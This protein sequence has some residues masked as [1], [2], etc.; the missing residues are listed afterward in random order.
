MSW[1][2]KSLHPH[3]RAVGFAAAPGDPARPSATPIY[4]TATFAQESATEFGAFDYSRSGNPT[5]AVLERHLAAIEYP[6]GTA[7]GE[8]ARAFAFA[9]GL[10]A[11]SAAVSILR[12]GDELVACDDLYGGSYRLFLRVLEPRGVVVRYA[13]LADAGVASRAFSEKTRLVHF[14]TPTN[15][16]QRIVDIRGIVRAVRARSPR[17]MVLVDS[18]A[19]SPWLQRPLELGADMVMHSATKLL[20]GHADVTAGALVMR[21]AALAE[22]IAFI[23]NAEGAALGPFDSYLLLRGMKTLGVRIERQQRG[24]RRVAAW[25]RSR[26]GVGEVYFP[27]TGDCESA[28]VHAS[29]AGG[30]GVVIS[31]RTGDAGASRALVES[32]ELF[33]IAVS[34]GSVNSTAS[35]PCRMSHASIPDAVRAAR[36][37]PEDLVRL[38]IGL[39]EAEDLI[40]DLDRA[41][42]AALGARRG[43]GSRALDPDEDGRVVGAGVGADGSLD[44]AEAGGVEDVIEPDAGR[45][46]EAAGARPG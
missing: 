11:L 19:M 37:M 20:N 18:T 29:Q 25:L 16:L 36:R 1:Q 27:G 38:S 32:L 35:L 30:P 22:Q 15:P 12:P 44:T 10:A 14:E 46:R 7:R 39:E 26:P 6:G 4:Q 40:G 9:S 33:S 42:E 24:A 43:S 45:E 8:P 34:F 41:I 31:F 5:R 2:A 21:D 23:Q 28:V 13:N 17:A 3:T